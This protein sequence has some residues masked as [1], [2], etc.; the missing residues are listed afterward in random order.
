MAASN[1]ESPVSSDSET[2]QKA[3]KKR[4]KKKKDKDDSKQVGL[5]PPLP[6]LHPFSTMKIIQKEPRWLSL[7]GFFFCSHPQS[8]KDKRKLIKDPTHAKYELMYDMLNGI[9]TTVCWV[10]PSK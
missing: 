2:H 4:D 8:K 9:R 6:F 7:S 5:D 3:R 1:Q 10:I